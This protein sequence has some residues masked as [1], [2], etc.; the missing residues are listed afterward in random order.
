[1]AVLQVLQVL[2]VLH[3]PEAVLLMDGGR[4]EVRSA[5]VG[6][7]IKLWPIRLGPIGLGSSKLTAPPSSAPPQARANPF[8]KAFVD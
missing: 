3:V 5:P 4:R 7:P 2:Q 8:A 6:G 1:M